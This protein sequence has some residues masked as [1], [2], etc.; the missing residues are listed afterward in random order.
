[1]LAFTN[2]LSKDDPYTP[3]LIGICLIVTL[4]SLIAVAGILI[5]TSSLK[6]I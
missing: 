1:M 6:V 2:V 3:E 5:L 4:A